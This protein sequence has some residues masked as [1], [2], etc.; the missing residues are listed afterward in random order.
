[1]VEQAIWGLGNIAGEDPKIR[2]LVIHSGAVDPVAILLMQSAPHTN[3]VRNASWTLSNFCRG[4]PTPPIHLVK[5]AVIA[6]AKI[7]LEHDIEDILIDVCW[8]FSYLTDGSEDD[9]ITMFDQPVLKRFVQL[10]E[11]P[12]VAISVPCLRSIGNLVTGSDAQTQA[13]IDQGLLVSLE[14]LLYH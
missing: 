5:N 10:L 9:M 12:N 7:F 2:D 11:Y 14:K 13:I 4:R 3:F 1:M 8:A 6:L